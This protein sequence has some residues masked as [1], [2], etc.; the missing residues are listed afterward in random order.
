MPARLAA[1]N[2]A[3]QHRNCARVP[4]GEDHLEGETVKTAKQAHG[5]A[6]KA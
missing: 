1:P 6:L 2:G 5:A 4:T 3:D